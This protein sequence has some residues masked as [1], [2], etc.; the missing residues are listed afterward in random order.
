MGYIFKERRRAL[1]VIDVA[2]GV[3]MSGRVVVGPA[4]VDLSANH[5]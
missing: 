2:V 3:I 5:R 1:C 4:A